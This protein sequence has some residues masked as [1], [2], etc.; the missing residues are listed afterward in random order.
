[1]ADFTIQE[2]DD[3]V[4]FVTKIVP[5]SSGPTRICGLLDGMLKIKVS[6]PPEKGKANQCLLKFL[7]K[8]I[9]M[10]K[11]AV[12]IIS[13]KTSPVK[14]VKVSG[15]SADKLLKKLNLN[16]QDFR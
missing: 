10:K 2:L 13:G 6:A 1:M 16:K 8:E 7:A 11:N 9:D 15:I 3:G 12:S 4:A 14:H 5:G